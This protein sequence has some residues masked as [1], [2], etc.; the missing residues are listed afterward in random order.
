MDELV[1]TFDY[2]EKPRVFE[3][4]PQYYHKTDKVR[5]FRA[6]SLSLVLSRFLTC[7][8]SFIFPLVAILITKKHRHDS[9]C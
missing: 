4:Y 5:A 7:R 3:Y 9:H 2:K 8:P 6:L 1:R